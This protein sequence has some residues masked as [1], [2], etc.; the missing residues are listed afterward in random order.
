MKIYIS[1]TICDLKDHRR[2]VIDTLERAGE[3]LECMK[4]QGAT[5]ARPLDECLRKVEESDV[6]VGI[7]AWRYGFIPTRRHRSITELE[8]G[9]AKRLG[10]PRFIFLL[11]ESASWPDEYRDVGPQAERMVRLRNKLRHERWCEDFSTPD[12]LAGAVVAAIH[13]HYAP[14]PTPEAFKGSQTLSAE[15]RASAEKAIQEFKKLHTKRT[16]ASSV[17]ASEHFKDRVTE[18]AGLRQC[19]PP[20][21]CGIAPGGTTA[22]RRRDTTR[23]PGM[24]Q[25]EGTAVA[26]P[27]WGPFIKCLR[28][29]ELC[30]RGHPWIALGSAR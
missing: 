14:P 7:F 12:K 8:Y 16:P 21:A 9:H 5:D 24:S 19:L 6:Y 10:K 11:E 1:S 23:V 4:K 25:R 27:V 15:G 22:K 30:V 20:N 18:L 17:T 3:K 2:A 26:K 13:R 29:G 28:N